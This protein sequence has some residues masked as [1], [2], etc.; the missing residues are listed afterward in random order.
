MSLLIEREVSLAGEE[1]GGDLRL[2]KADI[3]GLSV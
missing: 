1:G 3:D 2:K